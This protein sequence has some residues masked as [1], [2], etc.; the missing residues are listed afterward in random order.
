MAKLGYCFSSDISTQYMWPNDIRVLSSFFYE[1]QPCTMK[2]SF[3]QAL[4]IKNVQTNSLPISK[5][6]NYQLTVPGESS[7]YH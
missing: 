1:I 2:K 4:N 3:T 5:M 6:Y 7:A